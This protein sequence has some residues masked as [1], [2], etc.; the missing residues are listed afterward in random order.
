[1]RPMTADKT[2]NSLRK[3]SAWKAAESYGFDMSLIESNLEK[4]PYERIRAHS[5]ALAAVL[6]LRAAMERRPA[7]P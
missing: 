4:T 3:D 5:R 2:S 1:M 6:A 7:G